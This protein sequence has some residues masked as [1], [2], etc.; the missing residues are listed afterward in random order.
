MTD[1]KTQTNRAQL[2][3]G[4][5]LVLAGALLLVH[6]LDVMPDL[7]QFWPVILIALGVGKLIEHDERPRTR[8]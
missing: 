7:F 4:I 2:D 3:A 6:N 8:S 5:L 1:V